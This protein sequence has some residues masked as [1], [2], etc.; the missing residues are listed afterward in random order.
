VADP[1]ASGITVVGDSRQ[2]GHRQCRV[3]PGFMLARFQ[4]VMAIERSIYG[5]TCSVTRGYMVAAADS[6]KRYAAYRLIM[7]TNV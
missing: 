4:V 5:Y 2:R 6:L 3:M 1:G 7:L